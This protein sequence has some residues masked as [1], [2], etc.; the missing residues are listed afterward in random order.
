MV[1]WCQEPDE[2]ALGVKSQD[3]PIAL[4]TQSRR[5][6]KKNHGVKRYVSRLHSTP[7]PDELTKKTMESSDMFRDAGTATPRY[8]GVKR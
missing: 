3:T 1:S 6:D 7:S 8:L 4:N 2:Q 5:T